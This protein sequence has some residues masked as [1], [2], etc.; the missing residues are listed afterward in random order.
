MACPSATK[1]QA[2]KRRH[3]V[4]TTADWTARLEVATAMYTSNSSGDRVLT[5]KAL[6][7]NFTDE[8]AAKREGFA[9]VQAGINTSST[10]Y[11]SAV[12]QLE[13]IARYYQNYT[14]AQVVETQTVLE[15]PKVQVVETQ[16]VLVLETPKVQVVLLV[17]AV[18]PN[19]SQ[20]SL[21]RRAVL[22][23]CS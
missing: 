7:A 22:Q 11:K 8:I 10:S 23:P 21:K 2:S 12:K 6:G 16:T 17:E 13:G 14:E 3:P 20:L 18:R 4:N 5:T 19:G 9:T 1:G 15:T